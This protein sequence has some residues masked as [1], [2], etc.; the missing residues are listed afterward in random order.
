MTTTPFEGEEAEAILAEAVGD[1]AAISD[2]PLFFLHSLMV[3]GFRSIEK[4]T[5][6]FQPG[7]NVIIGANNAAKT[8]VIDALRIVFN[9]GT[10]ENKEDPIRLR[11]S[12][13]FI[14]C[15]EP[16]ATRSI[17]FIATF[18][19]RA[20][21][22]L[23]AQF[24]ELL[25]PREIVNPEGSAT[26]YSVFRLRYRVEFSYSNIKKRYEYAR[27][28]VRGGV[29]L[30]NPVAYEVLDCIRSIYLAPLRDLVNDR[31]RVG[32]EIERLILSHTPKGKE[33]E[34]RSIPDELR[35]RAADLI[36]KL[37]ENKHQD[38]AGENLANYASPYNIQKDSLSFLPAGMTE[39][40]FGT[41]WPVFAHGLHGTD[42]L[43]LSSN[44]L[45]INQ[46]IYA[47]IVLSRRGDAEVDRH[48][49]K[50]FLIE[51][52]EAHLHPQLQDSFFHALNQIRDHQLFVT[53]HSP[54]ITAKT[55][56]NRIIVMRRDAAERTA[57]PLHLAEVY[58]GRDHDGRYLHKFLDVTRSQLLFAKGALFVEGI[59][60]AMLMQLFSELIGSSLRAAGV[61]IV[62]INSSEGY[63]HFRPLF[64]N[65]DGAF[66]RAVFVTDNDEDP[67]TVLS[68]D[69]FR[70][71][72]E[73]LLDRPLDIDGN[74]AIAAGYGTFE[75][76]LLRMSIASG[77]NKAMQEL[78]ATAMEKAAPAKVKK[79]DAAKA[80][81]QDFFDFDH[82]ARA[83]QKM[84]ERTAGTCLMPSDWYGTWRTNN[85]FKAAKSD[86]AFYLY[87]A[88]SGLPLAEARKR[89]VVPKY[90]ER[91][92]K[93]VVDMPGVK[94]S[95]DGPNA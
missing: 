13:I 42:G 37:T 95:G 14:D 90:I 5:F 77:E 60:E 38:A 18:Y 3:E 1:T 17:T 26:E 25:C 4:A 65:G 11:P 86:F 2:L 76:G 46:L 59:T 20:D 8:A 9:L 36:K 58:K 94:G 10:F 23:P 93:Y 21:S 68:D 45:G 56:L 75:F 44:G 49:R 73:G 53:S 80:F 85:Y 74:T 27:N 66:C 47:S 87:Q 62:V 92:I 63:G 84:K 89:F 19:G 71:D 78:L 32:A 41:M 28:D 69:K 83:Y 70:A 57:T 51:E 24:F 54:T 31:V 61:E 81:A 64:D 82:P 52:P 40:L 55:D 22:D 72:A 79:R 12:D 16:T 7:L 88:L 35:E 39:S 67:R 30:R 48:I 43:P 91:A 50:F 15:S 34:R 29:D 6:T 33:E